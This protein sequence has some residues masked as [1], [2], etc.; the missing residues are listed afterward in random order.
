MLLDAIMIGEED[1]AELVG[2]AKA[3]G[4]YAFHPDKLKDALKLCELET[5]LRAAERPAESRPPR[6]VST[7]RD[8]LRFTSRRHFPLDICSESAD[9]KLA[10][11]G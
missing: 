8:L 6:K 3:S 5:L 2:V 4:G 1:S 11:H 9:H 7:E 10:N